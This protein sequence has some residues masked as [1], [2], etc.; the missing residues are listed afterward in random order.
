M[1]IFCEFNIWLQPKFSFSIARQYMHM[2]STFFS[3]KE[4]KS[5]PLFFKYGWTHDF[6]N[7]Q[8]PTLLKLFK[9]ILTF[10]LTHRSQKIGKK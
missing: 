6:S 2:H 9:N 8:T 5:V 3:R 1:A 10:Y 7:T 4:E